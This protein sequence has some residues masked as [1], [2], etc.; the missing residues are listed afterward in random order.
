MN[1]V[2]LTHT[3]GGSIMEYDEAERGFSVRSAFGT[4]DD[5]LDRLRGTRIDLDSTLVG[6][7][8]IE[9]RPL[10]EPDL[11]QITLD[12]HLQ[13][14]YD[15]G[16]RS[17]AAVPML[18]QSRIIGALV[19]RRRTAGPFTDETLDLLQNFAAQ[20]AL[21][22]H[23]ARLFREVE[24]KS[25]ELQVVSQH[26]SEFLASM[27]HELRTPLNAVIG[28]SEVLLEK[29]FGDLNERQE[30]YLRD[31]WSSGKHLLE[32]LN[33]IL[34]LSKVE[35]G[36]MELD[37]TAFPVRGALEYAMSLVRERASLHAIAL[38]LDVAAD[39][40]VV[41]ADELRFK[42]V[43]LNLVTNAVK[44]TP[45]GGSVTVRATR[46]GDDLVVAVTDTGVG[47]PPEDRDRIFE[48]FQQGGRGAP[49]EEGTGLGLTLS[50]RIVELLNGR[51]WL[52]S[53]V[54]VGSTFTF[55]IP[56]V[57]SGSARGPSPDASHSGF[58]RVVLV[59]DDRPSLDLF[60]AYL[61]GA[62]LDVVVA[63]DGEEG[64]DAV[65][66]QRAA[67]VILDIRLPRMDGWDVLRALKADPATATVPVVVVSI[68]D[69]R[70]KGLALGAAGYLVK[71][72]RRDDLL[73]ALA[74]VGVVDTS[75]LTDT[76][77]A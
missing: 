71:P 51:L 17:V 31:I 72:V 15:G 8:T 20:S 53:E 64:L 26:K 34:D 45:A 42:Q 67:A 74:D 13:C 22:I 66:R 16:W 25:A 76:S 68:V 46:E 57:S 60:S 37:L 50:R 77:R 73:Q 61:E 33:E 69:E 21:A 63:R 11:D 70:A 40:D 6:R 28:F 4:A 65:R 24:T 12:S 41:E 52:T 59:E 62:A 7:A 43:V 18:R 55:S 29:M 35:A 9:G 23:N 48:S 39:L 5:V 27:S 58:P 56:L 75:A 2:R 38:S 14:L 1:A 44:F 10:A 47:V 3:D 54:G 49:K 32:L 30:D 19:V 36:K